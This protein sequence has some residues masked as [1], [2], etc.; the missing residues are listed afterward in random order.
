MVRTAEGVLAAQASGS[1]LFAGCVQHD[2]RH[3]RHV[4][5]KRV[6]RRVYTMMPAEEPRAFVPSVY[7]QVLCTS[8]ARV[9]DAS[10]TDPT[11]KH[12]ET[13]LSEERFHCTRT[14]RIKVRCHKTR[15]AFLMS[16]SLS[17]ACS[18]FWRERELIDSSRRVARGGAASN[19]EKLPDRRNL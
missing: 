9:C 19:T 18:R 14:S 2:Q 4:V 10:T 7:Y 15:G 3:C 13:Q 1:L 5:Q 6:A 8:A 17:G 16:E 11:S 12:Q